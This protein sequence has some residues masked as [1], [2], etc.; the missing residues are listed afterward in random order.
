[1]R[2]LAPAKVNLSLRVLGRR[3]DGYHDLSSLMVPVS[4]FDELVFSPKEEGD[5]EF[6]CNLPELPTDDSNL[7]VKAARLFCDSVGILPRLSISLQ[8]TIPHGAGLG[9][10]SSDAA[11]TLLALD[12]LYQTRL[13]REVLADLAA[14]LGSDVPFFVYQSAAWIGGRGERVEPVADLPVLPLL[15]MKPGF[16]V[17]TP[18]AFRTWKDSAEIPGISYGE[19]TCDG[20][21]FVNDLERPVFQ[22]Y[23]LLADLKRWLLG[24]PEVRAALMTGS[25]STVFAVLRDRDAG[26]K[27]GE[28]IVSEFGES[29]WLYVCETLP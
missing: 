12:A 22:K 1:M 3:P 13:P 4:V 10:G 26:F 24:R 9:G 7:V 19:Q 21:V 14:A 15:L 29:L 16:G 20:V 8:K 5:L 17:S 25:G 18:W 23:L 28:A 6:Y 2:W 11:T 27:V